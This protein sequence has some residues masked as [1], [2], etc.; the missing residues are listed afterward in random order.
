MAATGVSCA[1][2]V[3]SQYNDLKLGRIK[4]RFITYKIDGGSIVTETVGAENASFD[5]FVQAIP[6]DDCRYAVYDMSFT[7]SDGRAASKLVM[8]AWSP[9]TSKIKSKMVYAGSKD[10]LTRALVGISVKVTATDLS[11]LT[12]QALVEACKK[13]T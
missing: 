3:I 11:E 5:D 9:D 13:F 1:D 4:A 10:A 7:T 12:E 2:A 8:V 6:A